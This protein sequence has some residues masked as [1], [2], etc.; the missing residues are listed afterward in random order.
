MSEA[1]ALAKE[2]LAKLRSC[3]CGQQSQPLAVQV[4]EASVEPLPAGRGLIRCL[5]QC[6]RCGQ[7]HTL[8][9]LLESNP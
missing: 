2:A 6:D 7:A 8:A 3:F 9:K 1:E 4:K 5:T